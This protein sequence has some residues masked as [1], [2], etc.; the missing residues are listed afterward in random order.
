V[1]RRGLAALTARR[2]RSSW[3]RRT[4]S[5]SARRAPGHPHGGRDRCWCPAGHQAP[6]RRSSPRPSLSPTCERGG[7]ANGHGSIRQAQVAFA[8]LHGP[9][10]QSEMQAALR[11]SAS[12]L[13]AHARRSRPRAERLPFWARP[14]RSQFTSALPQQRNLD[15][16]AT[17]SH[18][19]RQE[20]PAP[21]YLSD[22]VDRQ[23]RQ[24]SIC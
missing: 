23:Q 4:R 20:D 13:V 3:C 7:S 24:L 11:T 18:F 14:R 9:E 12:P 6:P 22:S 5:S 15:S 16:T 2:R 21:T 1:D 10:L 19:I 8:A 17:P